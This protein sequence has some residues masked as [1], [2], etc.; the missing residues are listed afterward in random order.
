MK[1]ID[2]RKA[3][4][5]VQWP[6]L[7]Q[8]LLLIGFPA[9][10]VHLVMG[11]VETASYSVSING[12]IHGFFRGNEGSSKVILFLHT[13]CLHG[14]PNLIVEDWILESRVLLSPK[15]RSHDIFHLAFADHVLLL[16]R[17]D[18]SSVNILHQRL[19]FLAEHQVWI[20]ML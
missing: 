12:N 15:C 18:R 4:D 2:F 17:V 7:N 9:H 11:C 19:Q 14:V 16:Y 5:S 13:Y 8:L 10:F 3:F 20:L 6:F 1:K